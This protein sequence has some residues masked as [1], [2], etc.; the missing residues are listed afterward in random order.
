RYDISIWLA[1][2]RLNLALTAGARP[3]ITQ[4]YV[5]RPGPDASAAHRRF[6]GPPCGHDE[7][8]EVNRSMALARKEQS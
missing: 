2:R 8:C 6:Q 3:L 7:E 1:L 5:L 4:R